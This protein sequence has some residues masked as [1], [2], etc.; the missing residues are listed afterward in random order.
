VN[1]TGAS[2]IADEIVRTTM[3]RVAVVRGFTLIEVLVTVAI[4]S[5]L[6]AVTL[7]L[8]E[9]AVTRTKEQELRVALRQIRE[10]I[11]AYKR[12]H[13]EGRIPRK[14]GES[15]Y[16]PSLD[17]L[18]EGVVDPKSPNRAVIYFMR[19][20]PR[21]P[22]WTDAST[23]AARTWGRRSYASP[24]DNPREGDDVFDVFVPSEARGLNGVPYREW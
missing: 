9:R 18:V 11:D 6:A 1:A 5:I 14:A 10:G 20:I 22:L 12:A 2:I 21:N 3:P 17:L 19:R 24:P 4:L 13:D 16:P 23:P 15:G 8:A 7:P